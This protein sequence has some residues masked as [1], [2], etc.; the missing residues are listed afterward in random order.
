[1]TWHLCVFFI[2][3]PPGVPADYLKSYGCCYNVLWLRSWVTFFF[4]SK[5]HNYI[6][7]ISKQH[8]HSRRGRLFSE[9]KFTEVSVGRADRCGETFFAGYRGCFWA[10]MWQRISRTDRMTDTFPPITADFLSSYKLP[11]TLPVVWSCH[12]ALASFVYDEWRICLA[13]RLWAPSDWHTPDP[14]LQLFHSH[15][16][17]LASAAV[18]ILPLEVH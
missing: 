10:E 4:C 11:E 2:T 14:R 6:I 3:L 18:L 9:G 13:C 17:Q 8:C 15:R 1:M 5:W 12:V 7:A 16:H